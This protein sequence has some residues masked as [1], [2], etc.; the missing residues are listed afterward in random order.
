[1]MSKFEAYATIRAVHLASRGRGVAELVCARM[2]SGK[3]GES[4]KIRDGCPA[5]IRGS[6]GRDIPAQKLRAGPQTL[7]QQAF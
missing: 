2:P 7:K 3:Q 6:C 1:M 4:K 5:D